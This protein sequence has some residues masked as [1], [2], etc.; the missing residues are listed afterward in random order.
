MRM[1]GVR[2]RVLIKSVSIFKINSCFVISQHQNKHLSCCSEKQIN[3]DR[4]RKVWNL[5]ILLDPILYST[6]MSEDKVGSSSQIRVAP[7][8]RLI[9]NMASSLTGSTLSETAHIYNCK[10]QNRHEGNLVLGEWVTLDSVRV[11][12][13]VNK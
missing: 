12:V 1:A 5:H 7:T 11:W 8:V 6:P 13:W 10:G 2:R 9:G 3:S 4:Q